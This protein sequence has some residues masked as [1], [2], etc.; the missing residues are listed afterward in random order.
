MKPTFAFLSRVS[1][2]PI[3][4]GENL[5]SQASGSAN[6]PKLGDIATLHTVGES[7]QLRITSTS[8]RSYMGDVLALTN[9]HS[10]AP[11]ELRGIQSASF[12]YAQIISLA[13][14]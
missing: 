10:H 8:G 9:R 4:I 13:W 11:V 3:C 1:Q 6:E 5:R 12:T 2:G 14:R 7:M